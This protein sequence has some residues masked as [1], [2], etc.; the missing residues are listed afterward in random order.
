MNLNI[1]PSWRVR[2]KSPQKGL[3]IAFETTIPSI[4][5]NTLLAYRFKRHGRYNVATLNP[6]LI[7]ISALP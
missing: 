1:Q 7:N 4:W 5:P 6:V 3:I 2:Q